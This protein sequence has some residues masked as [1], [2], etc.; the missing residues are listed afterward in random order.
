MQEKETSPVI[1][2]FPEPVHSAE[3]YLLCSAAGRVLFASGA[4]KLIVGEDL[5]G[6]N[7][8]DFL[9][10]AMTARIVADALAGRTTSFRCQI[11]QCWFNGTSEPWVDGEGMQI[12]LFPVGGQ[13]LEPTVTDRELFVSRDLNNEL[14]FMLAALDV[15][16]AS[17]VKAQESYL[18]KMRQRVFRLIRLSRNLQD[19]VLA[20]RGE[21]PGIFE[22][23]DI[24]QLCRTLLAEVE[25]YCT[26]RGICLEADLPE[27]PVICRCDQRLFRR[28]MLQLVSNAMAAQPEGG[29]IFLKILEQQEEVVILFSDHGS[30]LPQEKVDAINY[31]HDR[32]DLRSRLGAGLGL[33]LAKAFAEFHGGRMVMLNE[34]ECR[35]ASAKIVL[36]K[37]LDK[38]VS[39]FHTPAVQYEGGLD[40]VLVE[41]STVLTPDYY[42][43]K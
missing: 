15:L 21:L 4:L 2:S 1:V 28:M 42:Q 13:D 7:L 38:E 41:L 35:G 40:T 39:A 27:A 24:S 10:D 32:N 29:T 34:G 30:G 26:K 11:H 43:K 9:E 16:E 12:L 3:T 8:N 18:G 22:L 20:E 14:T 37:N 31:K 6:R 5:T 19:T 17:A 33:P 36:P 25:P 23:L